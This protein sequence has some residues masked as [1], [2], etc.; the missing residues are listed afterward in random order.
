MGKHDCS[1]G[2]ARILSSIYFAPHC[3]LVLYAAPV[4]VSGFGLTASRGI[5]LGQTGYLC[6]FFALNHLKEWD[7]LKEYMKFMKKT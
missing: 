2:N 7:F 6:V 1:G 3:I 5:R 4:I